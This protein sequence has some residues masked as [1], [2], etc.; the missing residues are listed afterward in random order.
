MIRLATLTALS[1]AGLTAIPAE[2]QTRTVRRNGEVLI[3]MCARGAILMATSCRS[4][5]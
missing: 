2:A 5:Q 1:L 3:L 4:A